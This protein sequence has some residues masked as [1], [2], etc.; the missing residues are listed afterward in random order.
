MTKIAEFSYHAMGDY[1]LAENKEAARAGLILSK[2]RIRHSDMI[3]IRSM[4]LTP[5]DSV[6]GQEIG[7]VRIDV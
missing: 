4:G 7:K 3:T 2:M 5:V 1:Y 6:T